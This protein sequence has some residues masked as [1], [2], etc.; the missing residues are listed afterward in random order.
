M[1]ENGAPKGA[2][3]FLLFVL[4]C[5]IWSGLIASYLLII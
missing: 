3:F 5:S 4:E 2:P 1:Y